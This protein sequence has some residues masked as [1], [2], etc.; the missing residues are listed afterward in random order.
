MPDTDA[1]A[2][3]S[4][5]PTSGRVPAG[6]KIDITVKFAP[7]EAESFQRELCARCPTTGT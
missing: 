5:T 1:A 7:K 6:G 2:P 3:F 4:V